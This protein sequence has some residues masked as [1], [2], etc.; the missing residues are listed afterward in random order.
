[1]IDT[2]FTLDGAA[3]AV[4]AAAA[5]VLADALSGPCGCSGVR[6]ACDHGACGACMVLVDGVPATSCS[7]L[8]ATVA[9][10]AITTVAGLRPPQGPPSAVQR[11]FVEGAAFQCGM[12]TPGMVLLAEA[13]LDRNPAPERAEVR[14]WM[15]ANVCRCT[16]YRAIEDAVLRAAALRRG[17]EEAPPRSWRPEEA[18]KVTGTAFFT[19]DVTVPG[20]LE[21]KILRSPH[22]HAR[23]RTIHTAAAERLP[24]V[25]A[26]VT[27]ADL[28]DL[29]EPCYGLWVKDQP[30]IAQ[31]KVRHVGDPVAAVAA[32]DA[33][34][35][36]AALALIEVEYEPLP[37]VATVEEALA[38]G[39]PLLFEE[40]SA[41]HLGPHGA[42]VTSLKEPEP[43][44]LYEFRHRMGDVDAVFANADHV[45]CDSFDFSRMSH[46]CLESIVTIARPMGEGFELWSSNQD[47][48]FLRQDLS[49]IFGLPEH[50]IRIHT[51]HLGS[52]FGLKS[53]CKLEPLTVLLARKAGRAVR[54][55][56]TMD[57]GFVTL[58]QHAAHLRL[59]TAV[60]ADGRLLARRSLIHLDAGAYADGSAL[61]ADKVGY[62]V[63]G[64]YLWE[65]LDNRALAVR[66]NTVPAG[67]YRGFGGTQA[68]FA[69][70]SQLD[71]IARR[72]G[73]DPVALRLRNLLPPGVPY[74]PGDS[75]IDSDLHAGLE[76]VA[77]RIGWGRREPPRAPHL[78]RGKG[79]AIGFKDAGGQGRFAQAQVK[80]VGDGRAIISCATVDMGQG[81]SEAFR[82]IV[83]EVLKMSPANVSRAEVDTDQTA[84]DQGTHASSATAVTGEAV[85]RAAEAVR[86]RILAFAAEQLKVPAE[87]LD[88]GE[89]MVRHGN[90]RVPLKDLVRGYYGG[91]GAEFTGQGEIKIETCKEAA[92]F[93]QIVYWMPNWVGVEV[94]VDM[95]TGKI[96]LLHLVSA[97]DAGRAL[98]PEAVR[99]QIEGASMQA[100]GQTLFEQLVFEGTEL[101]TDTPQRYRMPLATDLP[102]RFESVIFEQGM[103]RGPFGAKGVGEAGILGVSSAIANAIE[104]AV[105]VRLTAL[106]FT[107]D[108]VLAALDA[109]ALDEAGSGPVAA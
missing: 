55:A 109:K 19:S 32:R 59:E 16:G 18:A 107:P 14:A 6:V 34:T 71:M 45:F 3:V 2:A 28:A 23:I 29:A 72:L 50:L 21:A 100:V 33:A 66:T 89:G 87:S 7:T 42:G 51:L 106:P 41:G 43:N 75:A 1:M 99:G 95:E 80:V 69:S 62:R 74:R 102:E 44:V 46:A 53:Y 26:V 68:A 5:P 12:C 63:G 65:A 36:L 30:V 54:L 11:A 92:L 57:E 37:A 90:A 94:E 103:G 108:K 38:P 10:R 9:G 52:A 67:S 17:E 96:A 78:A 76:A 35:A 101:L 31:D 70:E 40:P 82:R 56:L 86:G 61:V 77:A 8:T 15:G 60:S 81:A 93:A 47:P 58:S 98:V 48:F 105:G 83:A 13:L 73:L 25:V 91:L 85:R 4:D 22:A 104:D 39:A 88:Y 24:G 49:D 79:I 27:G 20:V 84:F 97:A 64:P